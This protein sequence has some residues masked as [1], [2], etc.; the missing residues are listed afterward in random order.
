MRLKSFTAETMKE[1]MDMVRESLGDDAI[2]VSSQEEKGHGVRIMAALE[3]NDDPGFEVGDSGDDAWLQYDEET[4]DE[5]LV[6]EE[7]TDVLLKHGVPAD[8]IDLIVSTAIG[9]GLET[10][11]I[12]LMAAF[13]HL[14][15]FEEIPETA[16]NKPLMAVG[17]P[18]AGKTLIIAK[19]ATRAVV[20]DMN[21][22]VVT[23]DT[24]RAGGVQQIEA[25][26]KLLGVPLEKVRKAEEL[27]KYL[28]ENKGKFDQILIDMPGINPFDKDDMRFLS[29]FTGMVDVQPFLI[30]QAGM[31]ADETAEMAKAFAMLGVER[32]VPT[33]LDLAR[34]L[35]GLLASAQEAGMCFADA[36]HTES[37][38]DGL[39]EMSAEILTDYFMPHGKVKA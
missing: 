12:A 7:I 9:M 33:R 21:I 5:D 39:Q 35:G 19:L 1:A 29:R 26:T 22:A 36:S 10:P 15:Q 17:A 16:A 28:D 6:A 32:M 14:Y 13:E 4:D 31:D 20:N 8:I 25:F 23:A 24:K 30:T 37:V 2:I 3:Q 27:K 11:R 34:R 18:G 38:A